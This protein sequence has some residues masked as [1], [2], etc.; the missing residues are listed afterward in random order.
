MRPRGGG[1]A[2]RY[3]LLAGLGLVFILPLFWMVSSSLKPDYEIFA[4]PAVWWPR[5]PRWANYIEALISQ[6][7]GRY[8]I[9][10]LIIAVSSIVGHLL[11]CSL[12]AY[13]FARLRAPGKGYLFI[14]LLATLMLPYPV[15]MVPLFILFSRLGWVN[16]FWPLI[17]PTFFG[18]AF[19]IFLLRQSFMQ[20]PAELEDAAHMDGASLLQ[21]LRYVML[22]LTTPALATVAIFT[23]QA[24]WNDFL[25]PLIFLHDQS[26]YTLMLGLSFFRGAYEIQW[27]YLMAASLVVVLPVVL[28]FFVAQRGFVEGL[29]LGGVK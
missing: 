3:L 29:T 13:G 2:A 8:A 16:T 5:Q 9:N 11:S 23:F 21:V 25:A 20:I 12:V 22:P 15:T 28:L 17:L 7:F 4:I 18:N 24:S 14:L 27:A 19:Y 1:L 10:T 26:H 6:P